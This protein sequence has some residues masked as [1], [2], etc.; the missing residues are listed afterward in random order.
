MTGGTAPADFLQVIGIE[1]HF[2]GVRALRGV[3]LAVRGGEVHGLVGANGAGKSTLIRILAGVEAPDAGTIRLDGE[4]ITIGSPHR[5]TELGLSFIHQELNLVTQ[6]TALENIVL[7]AK[8]PAR[9]GLIDWA[10]IRAEVEPVAATVG[11]DFPLDTK[12]AA[13]STARRWLVS[14]CRALLGRARL[15]VMDEPTASLSAPEAENLFRIVRKLQR[16]GIATLYVSHRLDEI[17]ELCDR[18]TAFRDGSL[19]A[20]ISRGD[21]SRVRLIESIVGAAAGSEAP[22]V[23]SPIA[24][25]PVLQATGL[26]RWPMV[27]GVDFTLHRGEVL[28]FAGLVGAG[29]SELLRLVYGADRPHAGTMTLGER[30]F[31][32]KSP[33]DAVRAGVGLVPEERRSE[34]LILSRSVTYN[35]ALPSNAR[36][37]RSPLPTLDIGRRTRWA[38]DVAAR[39]QVKTPSVDTPVQQLSG[40]NQQK[41]VIG[42]WIDRNLRVLILDEPSRGVDIGA[43]GEIHRMIRSLAAQ[44]LSVIV[45]SSE[46]EELPGLCDRVLVMAEGRIVESLAGVALTRD[47]IIRASYKH[48]EEKAIA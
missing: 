8:K 10:R 45:V 37:A 7:G 20:E 30:T 35:M 14:I 25:K 31:A 22:P 40:G 42:R 6:L 46:P 47:A 28:G 15:I 41:V 44:G 19:V 18:V 2:G 33:R 5:A 29:R 4:A 11:I 32:P 13:L 24:G 1:K 36:F 16:D 21:L 27:R 9:F 38:K 26:T 23:I 12:V 39:M 34:G 3:E 43:R 48:A 17:L